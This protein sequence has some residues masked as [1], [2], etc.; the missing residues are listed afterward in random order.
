MIRLDSV[1]K[2]FPS[3]QVAVR[4]LTLEI[5]TGETCVLIGP[6]GSGKTTT[7]KMINRLI[8]PTSG[9]IFHDDEDVTHIDPVLLRLRMGYVI[10][11][12]G[13]FP[14]R[15][16][17]ENVATVPRLLGWS[18]ER[19]RQRVDELLTLVELDPVT[20]RGRF[21]HQLS[22]GQRQ[23][24]GVARAL[25]VDPPVLL[26]DEPFGAVDRI[27]RDRLQ[28]EFLRIQSDVRKTVILVTHDIDEA[29]KLGDRIAI[30]RQGGMLEQHDTPLRILASPAS[31][32]V[33][34][35]LGHDRG[36]KR[37]AITP[38]EPARLEQP[39]RLDPQTPLAEARRVLDA[40][41]AT[42]GVVLD[43]GDGVYGELARAQAQGDGTAR[44][45]ARQ[46]SAR[47]SARE[48][49]GAA[50]EQMLLEEAGWVP[51]FDEGQF[52]GVLTPHVLQTSLRPPA[53]EGNH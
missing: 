15:S 36:L 19:I 42:W 49:L 51:V 10:Q 50:L 20:F 7:L 34:D 12:V 52:R 26:M 35:L 24:V 46:V 27:N 9:R 37:L 41:G 5:R 25:A 43:G 3:G 47:V 4:D 1:S 18:R 32:L 2:R 40:R 29:V 23:R 17:A 31:D 8:E 6:S 33:S 21:P 45:R 14:H 39:P 28:N 30:L 48:T 16:V 44:E 11:N 13:L 22:G 53:S 38:I